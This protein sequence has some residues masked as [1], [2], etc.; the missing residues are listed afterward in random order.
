MSFG[1]PNFEPRKNNALPPTCEG[2]PSKLGHPTTMIDDPSRTTTPAS[3]QQLQQQPKN[4]QSRT[5]KNHHSHH[6]LPSM[7]ATRNGQGLKMDQT[8]LETESRRSMDYRNNKE[9]QTE[10]RLMPTLKRI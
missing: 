5:S 10:N 8:A 7:I 2:H 6:D 4:D 3:D 1:I 9:N